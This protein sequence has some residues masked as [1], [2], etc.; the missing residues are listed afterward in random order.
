MIFFKNS[1]P[2]DAIRTENDIQALV[3]NIN[4]KNQNNYTKK[5]PAVTYITSSKENFTIHRRLAL[6]QVTDIFLSTCVRSGLDLNALEYVFCRGNPITERRKKGSPFPFSNVGANINTSFE[7]EEDDNS[8]NKNSKDSKD[9]KGGKG[10]DGKGNKGGQGTSKGGTGKRK[11]KGKNQKNTTNARN[12][13]QASTSS[14]NTS[15]NTSSSTTTAGV[16]ILSEFAGC[17]RV[18]QGALVVNPYSTKDVVD[19]LDRALTMSL[20]ERKD[21]RL[22]DMS[23]MYQ[24]TRG[25]WV[26]RVISDIIR[27]SKKEDMIYVGTGFGLN[28]RIGG[29]GRSFVSLDVDALV[30]S[31]KKATKRLIILNYSGKLVIF[32]LEKI[33]V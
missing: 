24:N 12:T 32:L 15:S 23:S 30:E 26:R 25:G 22:R 1:R 13:K 8:D 18:L 3:S 20:K 4:Q 31:Y 21:R 29:Y 9:G 11:G 6:W 33:L 19:A 7:E 17:C 28:Y 10:K 16:V 27:S 5:N 2:D 14:S